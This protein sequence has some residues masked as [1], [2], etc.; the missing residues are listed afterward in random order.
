MLVGLC[1][2]DP[3]QAQLT[4]RIHIVPVPVNC[5]A[6]DH[7]GAGLDRFGQIFMFAAVY[8]VENLRPAMLA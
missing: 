3:D 5:A 4:D 8:S 2:W 7:L 6:I 1:T